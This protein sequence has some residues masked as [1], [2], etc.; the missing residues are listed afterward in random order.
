MGNCLS[1]DE[2][3]QNEIKNGDILKT[4]SNNNYE[5]FSNNNR[6]IESEN[7]L[8]PKSNHKNM[9]NSG[10]KIKDLIYNRLNNVALENFE[11]LGEFIYNSDLPEDKIEKIEGPIELENGAIY[12]GQWKN[13][14]RN[15]RGQQI[16]SDG[17]IYQ[18]YWRNDK[19]NGK[20]RLIHSDGDFYEGLTTF[21]FFFI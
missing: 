9:L 1:C 16:W 3:N 2:Y 5:S 19:A 12:I 21:L 7:K 8:F 6:F 17:S 11:T 4:Q 13:N 15:G 18:G 20:G 14:L 10:E